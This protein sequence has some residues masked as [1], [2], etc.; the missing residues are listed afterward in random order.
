MLAATGSARRA[1]RSCL[2]AQ[3]GC[4]FGLP[5]H[6]M[7]AGQRQQQLDARRAGGARP[8][9]VPDGVGGIAALHQQAAE[10]EEH[11]IRVGG[12]GQRVSVGCQQ[13]AAQ[14]VAPDDP[15]A[16]GVEGLLV[17]P[18]SQQQRDIL[19]PRRSVVRAF[20]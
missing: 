5:G 20:G 18:F 8:L 7:G 9:Q 13:I 11:R 12:A 1:Q 3:A 17:S 6:V 2:G 14:P 4:H 10:P 16:D 19:A 15:A